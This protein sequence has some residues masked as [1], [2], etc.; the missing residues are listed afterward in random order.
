MRPCSLKSRVKAEGTG[1]GVDVILGLKIDE[2]GKW[3]G[4]SGQDPTMNTTFAPIDAYAYFCYNR[5]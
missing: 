1:T 3:G 2:R 5:I 4:D